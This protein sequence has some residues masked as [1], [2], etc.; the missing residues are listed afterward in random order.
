MV[1]PDLAF[2]RKKIS[3]IVVVMTAILIA[4]FVIGIFWQL[5]GFLV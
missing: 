2:E 1:D 3:P 5:I 4:L